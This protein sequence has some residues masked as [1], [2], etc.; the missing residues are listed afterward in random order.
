[1]LT[2]DLQ[3]LYNSYL[4]SLKTNQGQP[5]TARKNFTEL[6]QDLSALKDL[7]RIRNM[8]NRFTH[9]SPKTYFDAPFKLHKDEKYFSLGYFASMKAIADYR[10]YS[11]LLELE[12]PDSP[13]QIEFLIKSIKFIGSY[14]LQNKI[15]LDNYL[16]YKKGVTYEWMIHYKNREISIYSLMEFTNVY[17]IICK[18]END[19]KGFLIDDLSDNFL[20]FKM[21]YNK[22]IK[23]KKT[24]QQGIKIIKK[25]LKN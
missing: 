8:L 9:I 7:M 20:K 6:E 25:H 21:R 18:I 4:Y 23:A 24:L 17:D 13:N 16:T 22:S 19:I 5:F 10:T 15:S 11:K 12:D 2:K 1:M 3:D 14:C